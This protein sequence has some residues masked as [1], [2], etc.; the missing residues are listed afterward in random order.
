METK[1][2]R[3]PTSNTRLVFE[4]PRTNSGGNNWVWFDRLRGGA[5]GL[6]SN[7]SGA[8]FTNSAVI[9]SDSLSTTMDGFRIQTA[10]PINASGNTYIYYPLRRAPGFFDVVCYTGTSSNT[11]ISH[12]LG[13][14]PELIIC[15]SRSSN[16]G[17]NWV[18]WNQ[19]LNSSTGYLYLNAT[20][21]ASNFAGVWNGAP[22]S[23]YFTLGTNYQNN[24][25]GTT[26]VAY[27][28]ASVSGVSKVGSYTGNG[29]SVTVTT[30]FQPRFILV[31]RTDSTG[32]WL[33]SDSARGLVAGNDP[34]LELNTTD[35]EVTNEDWV[36]ISSTSFT[37]N[38][39][40]NNANVNTGTYIYLCIA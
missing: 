35:A 3:R 36:D 21:E 14:A 22:T 18:V 4:A 1:D 25:S 8:E 30:D 38:Q 37:V 23:T 16:P 7:N 34:Y 15:K 12:N 13:V 32:D 11:T 24:N 17:A 28:F 6:S 31:K 19:T 33:V 10:N 9:Q 29:S 39:T 5:V 40:T 2:S 27:L 26:F 20:L